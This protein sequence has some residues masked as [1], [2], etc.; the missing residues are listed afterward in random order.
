ME[1][2]K[3]NVDGMSIELWNRPNTI[4]LNKVLKAEFNFSKEWTGV[5]TA[6]FKVNNKTYPVILSEDNT[7]NIPV[8]CY[9]SERLVFYVG[10]V[11]ENITTNSEKVYYSE[12]CYTPNTSISEPTPDVYQQIIALLNNIQN[13]TNSGGQ[14]QTSS[15]FIFKFNGG[16]SHWNSSDTSTCYK[17]DRV[18]EWNFAPCVLSPWLAVG[19]SNNLEHYCSVTADGKGI[20]LADDIATKIK[21]MSTS[22]NFFGQSQNWAGISLKIIASTLE[23]TD[24]DKKS[25]YA[26]NKQNI[27]TIF[28]DDLPAGNIKRHKSFVGIDFVTQFEHKDNP[29]LH[30]LHNSM[31][32]NCLMWSGSQ[33][34]YVSDESY[35][36]ITFYDR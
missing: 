11:C 7:C 8:E 1:N 27:V 29:S 28:N 31:V 21:K 13:P 20:Q 12:S 34:D 23:T 36:M 15:T 17:V 33:D 16:K 5:K 24:A 4:V 14:A 35:V 18:N 32:L 30:I 6:L 25:D 2:I 3:F 10:C 9:S 26:Y 19:N 22:G